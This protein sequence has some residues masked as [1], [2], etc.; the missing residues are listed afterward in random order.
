[1]D[2]DEEGEY[3]IVS[4]PVFPRIVLPTSTNTAALAD[5][6]L[7]DLA[8]TTV[9][10]SRYAPRVTI[11]DGETGITKDRALLYVVAGHPKIEQRYLAVADP[12]APHALMLPS[13]K[14]GLPTSKACDRVHD[15]LLA[16]T[17]YVPIGDVVMVE[18]A[19]HADTEG[20]SVRV[21]RC[22]VTEKSLPT[23]GQLVKWATRGEL[24]QGKDAAIVRRCCLT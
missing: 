6:L 1:M 2:F 9:A 8:Y 15:L 23:K 22:L 4:G 24:L 17:G 3:V 18:S 10:P 7:L 5:R 21:C 19:T 20:R 11:G 16:S 12:S 13:E 14:Y